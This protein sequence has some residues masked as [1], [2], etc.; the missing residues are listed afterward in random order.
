MHLCLD[1]NNSIADLCQ[2]A[3][4]LT[5][6][7]LTPP[8]NTIDLCHTTQLL[9]LKLAMEWIVVTG[10]LPMDNSR[11]CDMHPFGCIN[12][13]VLNWEDY[14]VRIVLWL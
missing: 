14:G 12:L 3:V 9:C 2:K 6:Q 5:M 8:H 1:P 4:K 7:H 10:F 11:T 13:L